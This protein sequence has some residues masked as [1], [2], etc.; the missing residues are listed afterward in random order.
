M[1]QNI[2]DARSPFLSRQ[3]AQSQSCGTLEAPLALP[4]VEPKVFA[5]WMQLAFQDELIV[6]EESQVHECSEQW[7]LVIKTHL[8]AEKL[9]DIKGANTIMDEILRRLRTPI[10]TTHVL[11]VKYTFEATKPG[12]KL[13][14]VFVDYA[15]YTTTDTAFF[16]NASYEFLQL[17]S[18]EFLSWREK[19]ASSLKVSIFDPNAF[20]MDKR[21]YH[22]EAMTS[23]T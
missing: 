9:G 4:D 21:A 5:T 8:L 18:L 1:P 17:V 12:S 19:H 11:P 10:S 7:V 13:R 3:N 22:I 2:V 15:V 20:R 23:A 16:N 14:T 6:D